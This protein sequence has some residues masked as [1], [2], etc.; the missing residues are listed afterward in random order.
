MISD[1]SLYTLSIFL[2][3]TAMLAIVAYHFLEVNAEPDSLS[4]LSSAR[5]A[6]TV[7]RAVKA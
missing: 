3:S 1:A 6:D 7:P 5:K 2:G 4:P